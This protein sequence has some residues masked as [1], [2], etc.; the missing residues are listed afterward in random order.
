MGATDRIRQYVEQ[1]GISKYKFCKNLGVSNKFL[2]NSSN[3]GTDKACKILQYFPEVSAEWLITG[4]GEMLKT[5]NKKNEFED[6]SNDREA[7]LREMLQEKDNEI[8]ILNREIG[9]LRN[10]LY[11]DNTKH[12]IATGA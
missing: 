5:T 2:D 1:K 12:A 4:E 11:K 7:L 6:K 10:Q 3:M 8:R 9:E